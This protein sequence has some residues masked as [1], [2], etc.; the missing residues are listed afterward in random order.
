MPSFIKYST[1]NFTN[2]TITPPY[3]DLLA[4]YI[5]KHMTIK[6][7]LQEN[8]E[9]TESKRQHNRTAMYL[10]LQLLLF[11]TLPLRSIKK[12]NKVS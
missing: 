6:K 9:R 8:E 3:K 5:S 12:I 7:N 10:I 1:L 2:N 4:L 11:E